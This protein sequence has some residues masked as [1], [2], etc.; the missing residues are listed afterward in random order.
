MG[1][2]VRLTPP[3]LLLSTVSMYRFYRR[4][5]ELGGYQSV[6]SLKLWR[7]VFEEMG[8]NPQH[9]AGGANYSR[10]LFERWVPYRHRE[11][12]AGCIGKITGF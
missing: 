4:V 9:A 11:L 5:Q 2:A 10:R 1:F 3:P 12:M 6:C 7:R 8:G